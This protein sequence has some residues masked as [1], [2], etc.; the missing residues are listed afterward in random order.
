MRKIFRASALIAASVFIAL[1]VQQAVLWAS[2]VDLPTKIDPVH[3]YSAQQRQDLQDT[4]VEA[5]KGANHSIILVIFSMRNP[6][7]IC[8]LNQK[9]KEGVDVRVVY[10]SGASSNLDRALSPKVKKIK[11]NPRGIA[12]QKIL[13]IDSETVFA[14]S[15]NM[16]TASLRYMGNL[17]TGFWSPDLAKWLKRR[18]DRM[19]AFNAITGGSRTFRINGQG[20]DFLIFPDPDE[21]PE[22]IKNLIR[23]AKKKIRIAMFTWTREDFAD[24]VIDAYHRGVDVEVVIDKQSGYGASRKIVQRMME[25][26]V[27]LYASRGEELLHFK[28]MIIDDEILVNGSA[29]W[30]K[31]AFFRNDDCLFI[32]RPL[33]DKQKK[34]LKTLWNIVISESYS[35]VKV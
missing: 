34:Y 24:E 21:G 32:L 22:T 20:L 3:F 31:S 11:R 8:A 2:R 26:G 25:G 18:I 16:T 27:P 10:D 14:G 28:M 29:N 4:F 15:A 30:T 1:S 35:E 7:V 33:T 19:R 13:I 6:E 23:S 12:H 9:A 5:I 17:V